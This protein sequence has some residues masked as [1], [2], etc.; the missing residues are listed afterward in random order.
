M[1]IKEHQFE[2]QHYCEIIDD[3]FLFTN[4]DEIIEFMADA[5]Y[6][7]AHFIVLQKSQLPSAYFDLKTGFAGEVLQKFSNFR[8][9]LIVIGDFSDIRSESLKAF[10]IESKRNKT[11]LFTDELNLHEVSHWIS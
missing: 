2:G 11:V 6:Q 9:K 5:Y 3:N 1:K 7:G 10:I 4:A 8:M